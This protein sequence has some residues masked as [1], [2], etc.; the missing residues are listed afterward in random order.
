VTRHRRHQQHLR[1]ARRVLLLKC[2]NEPN[3]VAKPL[4]RSRRARDWPTR[5]CRCR[6]RTGMQWRYRRSVRGKR[7]AGA[8]QACGD[9]CGTRCDISG[10]PRPGS[11][12]TEIHIVRIRL[13][14]ID[15]IRSSQPIAVCNIGSQGGCQMFSGICTWCDVNTQ[16]A[17]PTAAQPVPRGPDRSAQGVS[18]A[19]RTKA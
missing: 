19:R 9:P 17:S 10:P 6:R 3:G 5:I 8:E 14:I 4:P 2:S 7:R 18:K 13:I 16:E 11:P 12:R 1:L 15:I